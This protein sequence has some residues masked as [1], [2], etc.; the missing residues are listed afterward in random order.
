MFSVDQSQFSLVSRDKGSKPLCLSMGLTTLK[1][2]AAPETTDRNLPPVGSHGFLVDTSF[3]TVGC[4]VSSPLG[5]PHSPFNSET[6]GNTKEAR[7]TTYTSCCSLQ[8]GC[9]SD[10]QSFFIPSSS[11]ELLLRSSSVRHCLVEMIVARL[12]QQAAERLQSPN[13]QGKGE[14]KS[15]VRGVLICKSL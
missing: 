1:E 10:S 15:K 7:S 5:S 9:L 13:L 14:A 6:P 8:F 12:P 2:Q 11:S 3:F 4:P